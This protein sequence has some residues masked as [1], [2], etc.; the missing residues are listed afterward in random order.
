MTPLDILI[1]LGIIALVLGIV[2]EIGLLVAMK[3]VAAWL[4]GSPS[5]GEDTVTTHDF[6]EA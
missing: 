6:L 1:F 3:K 5:S 2:I 4:K